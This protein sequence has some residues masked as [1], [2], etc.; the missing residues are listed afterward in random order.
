MESYGETCPELLVNLFGAYQTVE[1]D[2][3][4]AYVMMR[5]GMWE[6]GTITFTP[7]QLMNL[8]ENHY[9]S[10]VENGTWKMVTKK[11]ERIV[12]LEAQVSALTTTTNS[13]N[14]KKTGLTK[15]ERDKKYAWKFVPPNTEAGKKETKT[16]ENRQYHWCTKH[17]SWTL[18]SDAE[19]K[20][21]GAFKNRGRDSS[22]S[23]PVTTQT[24]GNPTIKVDSALSST[25]NDREPLV[26]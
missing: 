2:D 1:D 13:N 11:D 15:A 17:K 21:V 26:L 12:A 10:R 3:F 7:N 20:G 5:K 4:H 6:D 14:S 8:V 16:F 19:C 18:H 24:H 23:D 22:P 9:K 25:V